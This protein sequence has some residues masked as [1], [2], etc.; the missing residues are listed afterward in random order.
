MN[1]HVENASPHH[2][3]EMLDDIRMLDIKEWYAGTG[4]TDMEANLR[5]VFSEGRFA[6]TGFLDGTPVVMWG[7][8]SK[9]DGRGNV[10]LFATDTAAKH[11]ITLHRILKSE[12]DL[13]ASIWPDLEA[14]SD[15]RNH[16]HHAWLTWLGFALEETVF[17]APFG[18][19]FKK[20]RRT[21][22][23]R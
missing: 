4:S 10:W 1:V 23:V 20:F 16:T 22:C 14:L 18:L 19:P 6:R 8:D 12:M 9:D 15:E 3:T 7:V 5:H 11:A 17:L 21:S 13:I 2:V